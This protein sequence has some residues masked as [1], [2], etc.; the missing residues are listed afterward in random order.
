MP[1]TH[2]F[3][4]ESGE[5]DSL[6]QKPDFEI[7]QISEISEDDPIL[8]PF[9]PIRMMANR[10]IFSDRQVLEKSDLYRGLVIMVKDMQAPDLMLVILDDPNEDR[11]RTFD[12]IKKTVVNLWLGDHSI[13]SYTD[14]NWQKCRYVI[15]TGK[16]M[17][18]SRLKMITS[19]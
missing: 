1:T 7:S 8:P 6:E 11:V 3:V 4:E 15:N 5:V 9:T 19:S 12:P 14:Q 10:P 13:T 2:D 16:V 17:P 18:D